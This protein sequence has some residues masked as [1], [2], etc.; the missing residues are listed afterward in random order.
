MYADNQ[1]SNDQ[2]RG[3]SNERVEGRSS[4]GDRQSGSRIRKRLLDS[5]LRSSVDVRQRE[6]NNSMA[7]QIVDDHDNGGV[8]QPQVSNTDDESRVAKYSG[9]QSS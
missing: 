2:W 3:G 6:R 5:Q 7:N 9:N 8:A 4:F 1:I